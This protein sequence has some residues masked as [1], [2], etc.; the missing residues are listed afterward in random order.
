MYKAYIKQCGEGCDYTIACGET[1]I[2]VAGNTP[3]EA[4]T[5]L[6]PMI[7]EE[8]TEERR[9]KS[10]QL[11]EISQVISVN[12]NEIYRNISLKEKEKEAEAKKAKDYQ[13]FLKLKQQFGE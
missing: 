12:V 3:E 11:F 1:V 13:N 9:L 2:D 8:Y 7:E 5:N 4:I 10:I 6:I